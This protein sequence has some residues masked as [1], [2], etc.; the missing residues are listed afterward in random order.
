MNL[1]KLILGE[2][3]IHDNDNI[4]GKDKYVFTVK[5]ELTM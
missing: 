1:D 5:R 2:I 3:I 4:V